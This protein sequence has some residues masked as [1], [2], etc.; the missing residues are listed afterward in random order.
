MKFDSDLKTHKRF[1]LTSLLLLFGFGGIWATTAPIDGAAIAP[2]L[3][4]VKSYSKIVQHLE[5]GIIK[6]IF[7]ENGASVQADDPILEIDSTQPLAALEIENQR[8]FSLR[9]LEIRLKA[10]RDG[11]DRLIY[12]P[13]LIS[14]GGR[15][16]EEM[17][18]QIEI[19][20]ARRSANNGSTEILEQ[21][22]E[23]LQSQIIG[24]RGLQTSKEK[25]AVSYNEEL[26]DIRELLSQGFSDKNRLR[27]LERNVAILEGEIAELTS[28][29]AATEVAIGESRL[30]ILQQEKEFHNAVVS[31]L[32]EVQT[33][34]NDGIER[35]IAQEDVVSRTIVRAPDAGIVN[36]LQVHTIGGVI[37][38]GMRILDIVPQEDDLIIEAQVSPI[39]IDRVA[40]GQDATIR[41]SSFGMGTAP[42]VYGNV[43]SVSADSIIDDISGVPS[44]LARIEVSQESIDALAD[45][46]LLPGMPADVFIATGSRTLIQYIFKPLSTSLAKSLRED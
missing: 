4:A 1:G 15:A 34:I 5:G 43:L 39:D 37:A 36:G 32:R 11:S 42:S 20:G 16:N 44:Y 41:F 22:M 8:L 7:V 30:E 12:P 23:Q 40:V 38:P 2:G 21:R 35:A 6:D 31:E 24:F 33:G 13:S 45:L 9:A 46:S 17:D 25:L 29:I 27:E 18:A 26:S 19:F 10:E 14:T 28:T 3:V